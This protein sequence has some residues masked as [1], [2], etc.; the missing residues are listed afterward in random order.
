M[1]QVR[2][3]VEV[4]NGDPKEGMSMKLGVLA[5]AGLFAMAAASNVRAQL[6]IGSEASGGN[7]SLIDVSGQAAPRVL[8]AGLTARALAADEAGQMLYWVTDSPRR[9]YKAAY[10]PG[11]LTPVE[12]G[13]SLSA[14]NTPHS[15][16]WDSVSGQLV[17]FYS[18]SAPG[19]STLS[20][21]VIQTIDTS[22]GALT[23]IATLP[24]RAFIGGDYDAQTDTFYGTT[25][26]NATFPSQHRSLFRVSKPLTN[27]TVTEIAP[28]PDTGFLG[29]KGVAVGGGRVFLL[30]GIVGSNSPVPSVVNYAYHTAAGVYEPLPSLVEPSLSAGTWAPGL[31]TPAAGLDLVVTGAISDQCAVPVGGAV[32]MSVRV[33]NFGTDPSGPVTL[34]VTLPPASQATFA[35]S[36]PAPTNASPAQLEY[37]L[38]SIP[39]YAEGGSAVVQIVLNA[40]GDGEFVS[41]TFQ[42]SVSGDST[43]WN[44]SGSVSTRIRPTTPATAPIRGV[45]STNGSLANSQLPGGSGER[46]KDFNHLVGSPDGSKWLLVASVTPASSATD[47]VYVRGSTGGAPAT[48]VREGVTPWSGPGG[49]VGAINDQADISSSGAVAFDGADT[50]PAASNKYVAVT[51]DGV[52]FTE[53]AREGGPIP[54]IPDST[55]G[56]AMARVHIFDSGGV[57]F[58]GQAAPSNNG[59]LLSDSGATL[60]LRQNVTVP[61]GAE[62]PVISVV[63]SDTSINNAAFDATGANFATFTAIGGLPTTMDRCLVVNG[64]RVIQENVTEL[65]PG[66]LAATAEN[67]VRMG[68]D[69]TWMAVDRTFTYYR[70]DYVM[71]GYGGALLET[72]KTGDPIHVGATEAWS[73][74]R[75][76][77]TTFSPADTFFTF[78]P[79]PG[80]HYI[81]GGYTDSA[82]EYTDSVLV[83]DNV[84]VIARENDPVDLDGNGVFDD[85]TYVRSFVRTESVGQFFGGVAFTDDNSV[86]AMVGLRDAES[87]NCRVTDIQQNWALVRIPLPVTGACCVG[88]SCHM[89]TDAA[90]CPG[91][92][93]GDRSACDVPGQPPICCAADFNASGEVSV[94][95]IFDFLQAYF[96]GDP[97]A[98]FN[99]AGGIS[100]QDIFDFLSAWFVGC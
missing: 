8:V 14:A 64:A 12:I 41:L 73:D 44:N 21:G 93:A 96:A 37:V 3:R 97:R 39:G 29:F 76:T 2:T 20:D 45:F 31:M 57:A 18:V 72:Y 99:G 66:A 36:T 89:V 62:G 85:D 63:T 58:V 30:G 1:F 84:V 43:P 51:N 69:G 33:D 90:A 65:E 52:N 34:T 91:T 74:V 50:G 42:A 17:G 16:A 56:A 11:L 7:I 86:L 40:A 79:G 77:T 70:S 15:L 59:V 80:G 78:N 35:S 71:R 83:L 24:G 87:A 98:D 27:P 49:H 28:Y 100:V 55:Y 53:I 47:L 48:L 38:P 95:D 23:P 67:D 61:V 82:D 88:G 13:G 10:G 60:L 5:A 9:L 68:P 22:T 25:T 81:I 54:A 6:V 94:Q 19:E 75:G 46:F 92:Y 26:A 4:R 32:D